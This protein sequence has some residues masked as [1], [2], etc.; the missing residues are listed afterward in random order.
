MAVVSQFF[1]LG[2]QGSRDHR[3]GDRFTRWVVVSAPTHK[4]L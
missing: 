3:D 2:L 1:G 4:D